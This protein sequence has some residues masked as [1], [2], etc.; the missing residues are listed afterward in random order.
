VV[1]HRAE[2][3]FRWGNGAIYPLLLVSTGSMT[4]TAESGQRRIAGLKN[5]VGCSRLISDERAILFRVD[6]ELWWQINDLIADVL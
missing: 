6:S 4:S 2:G 3:L 1:F 5:V